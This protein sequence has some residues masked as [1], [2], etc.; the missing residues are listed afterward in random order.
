MSDDLQ[1]L[2]DEMMSAVAAAGDMTALEALR[3]SALGKKGA[4]TGQMKALGGL[5]PEARKA[6]G[7]ALNQIKDA[8]GQAIE[9]RKAG[10]AEAELE[11][12]LAGERVDVTLPA[13]PEATG[14]IHPISQ[15]LEELVAIYGEMGFTVAE[16]PD[17]ED[18]FHNFTAL[19]I[20][21]EHPA[22]QEHDTFYLPELADGGRMV[23][24]THTSPVQIRTMIET[25]PAIRII[26]PGRT[27]RADSDATHSP[28]FHQVEGLVV[29]EATH[30]GHLKGT[31]IEFCRAFFG[32]DDLPVR[33]RPSYF[34]FT[35]PSAEVDI[36]CTRD[37]GQLKIG[38]GDDW[39]EIL[40]CGMVHPKV[41]ENCGIDSARYQ[42]FAFGIG[43][44]RLAMLKYGMPDLRPFYD[45]D[46]RWLRHYGF[47]PL[48]APSLV[49]G[50]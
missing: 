40:G 25:E 1:K 41:L 38:H 15:T 44:E 34:P 23:L 16:G 36:G 10:F 5:D 37:G 4:I 24:R 35:E 29:D 30:M 20:P 14:H 45:S 39:L 49:R 27:F 46:L 11:A 2:K 31:L 17:I 3:V 47:M 19:N 6:T 42:G 12:R 28:M 43:I 50:L 48:E 33:F 32:I 13:R 7:Q 8:V 18:D 22:R 9:A 21:P 26:V